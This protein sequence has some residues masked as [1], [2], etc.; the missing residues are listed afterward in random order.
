VLASIIAVVL[1][2]AFGISVTLSAG[3]L[4]YFLLIPSALFSVREPATAPIKKP[5]TAR[6]A[7]GRAAKLAARRSRWTRYG[8]AFPICAA[9]L[10]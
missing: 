6:V 9:G 10:D 3:G 2:L 7:S 1:S 8:E 5:S 4:C